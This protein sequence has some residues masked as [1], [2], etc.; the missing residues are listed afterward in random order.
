MYLGQYI[1][2]NLQTNEKNFCST[3]ENLLKK[4][5]MLQLPLLQ[6]IINCNKRHIHTMSYIVHSMKWY[7]TVF[8]Y[9]Q[10]MSTQSV[11]VLMCMH[12]CIKSV[13]LL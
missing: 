1:H 2:Q 8:M 11:H 13:S 12:V 6:Y 7:M 10:Y 3:S 5:C 4:F 9:T